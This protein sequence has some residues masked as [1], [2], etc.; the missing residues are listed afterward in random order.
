MTVW[1][2]GKVGDFSNG[3]YGYS[4]GSEGWGHVGIDGMVHR[5]SVEILNSQDTCPQCKNITQSK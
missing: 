5:V 2:N 3:A 1:S 4:N